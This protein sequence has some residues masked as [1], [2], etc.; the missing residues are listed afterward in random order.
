MNPA[1]QALLNYIHTIKKIDVSYSPAMGS[2][3]IGAMIAESALQPG[4]RYKSVVR[5]CIERIV[6][7]YPQ[8]KTSKGFV[9]LLEEGSPKYFLNWTEDDKPRRVLAVAK[10][11]HEM[12][13]ETPGELRLLLGDPECI[14]GLKK[15][16]GLGN[17]HIDYLL[18][19]YKEPCPSL[20]EYILA[21]LKE[22]GL[23]YP[24][25]EEARPILDGAAEELDL[26]TDSLL[27]SLWRYM[28][29]H[30]KNSE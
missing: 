13:I 8:G 5:P 17:K 24:T 30:D 19:L 21:F 14:K 22:A 27:I 25:L 9:R 1:V 7:L 15:I 18:L 29:N 28:S 11:L 3:H 12:G 23:D 20:E 6:K 10:F 26:D 2:G 4:S 16:R